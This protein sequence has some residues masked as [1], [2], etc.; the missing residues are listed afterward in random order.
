MLAHRK[1]SKGKKLFI[2]IIC[3][4]LALL[5]GFFCLFEYKARDLVHNLID[6]ELEIHA[7]NAIDNAV[8]QVL[9]ESP[10]QYSSI[11]VS[12]TDENGA[13]SSLQT[14]TLAVNKLKSKLSMAITQNI[15]Q[16]Q[17]TRVGIPAGAFTGLVLLSDIGPDIFVSLT[18]GG[19][20]TTTIKSEFY[21]AGINQTIHR[22][23]LVVDADVSMTCPIIFYET[24]FI[25]EYELCH[26][27]IVGNTPQFFANT[28]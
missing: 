5:I 25:T 13:I 8:L 24:Q 21:S 11:I 12:N 28:G 17:K 20:V 4:I 27:V 10:V 19:S 15:R 2:K 3:V 16:E 22:V 7:M 6:N 26:T 18:L 1:L 23:Y 9:E 14:D